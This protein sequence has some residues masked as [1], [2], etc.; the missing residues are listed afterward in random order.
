MP[1]AGARAG[2]RGKD[3]RASNLPR[4]RDGTFTARRDG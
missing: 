1:D 3:H 4:R 2:D